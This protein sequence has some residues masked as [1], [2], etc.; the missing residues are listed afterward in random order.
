[1]SVPEGTGSGANPGLFASLR[2]F[3][4][5]LIAILYTRLDL[6]TAELEDEATSGRQADRCRAGRLLVAFVTAFFFA[7]FFLIAIFW[8]FGISPLMLSAASS[9]S[10][11]SIGI[12]CSFIVARSMIVNRP[13]FLSQTIAELRRDAEG[14][15]RAISTQERRGQAMS[16]SDESMRPAPGPACG[17]D[18]P[19]TRR[20]RR[21]L[22]QSRQADPIHRVRHARLR[23]SPRKTPGFSP[24]VPA[25]L[26][27]HSIRLGVVRKQT[28]QGCTPSAT[29][30]GTEVERKAKGWS[31]MSPSGA[32]AAGNSFKLYRRVRRYLP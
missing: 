20:T 30:A 31:D 23:I 7:I 25:A 14:L 13:K 16:E 15:S 12:I 1:M 24:L 26:Q 21:G 11:Y 19:P 6:V 29:Q 22:S 32:G 17:T 5:V 2:S 3:W 27:H 8:A 28:G 4:G 10:T 18:R 9:W